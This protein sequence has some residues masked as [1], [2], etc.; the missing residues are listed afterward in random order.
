MMKI[1]FPQNEHIVDR[2]LRVILGLVLLSLVF[3]GPRTAWGLIGLLP[4]FT[5]LV[6]SCPVYRLLGISTCKSSCK[7]NSIPGHV[8]ATKI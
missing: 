6:G 2:T 5:G 4:L 7:S 1:L 3:I 8:S